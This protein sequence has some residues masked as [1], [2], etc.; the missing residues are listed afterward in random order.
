MLASYN[1][2]NEYAECKL[3]ADEASKQ[4]TA[5]GLEVTEVKH[6]NQPIQ[7][8]VIAAI[9]TI[10]K[11]P[12]ADKLSLVTVKHA[13]GTQRVVCGAQNISV[14]KK[15]VFAKEG[16]I[17]PGNFAIKKTSIRG[18]ESAG[19]ICSKQELELED[20]S[21]G[22][23]ILPDTASLE[24]NVSVYTGEED[25]I[26]DIDLTANRSDCMSIVGI[27]QELCIISDKHMSIKEHNKHLEKTGNINIAVENPSACPRYTARIIQG[28]K[29]GPS[30][31]WIVKRLMSH[32]IRSINNI[33]DI[34]N[35]ILL[36]YGQP[37][38][39]F[40]YNKLSG[41]QII[42]RNAKK[43]EKI[44]TLDEKKEIEL[45][46]DDLVICD[47]EKPV[48]L[49]GIMGGED[50]GV[51][52][53]T[54]DILLES[55]YFDPSH[56]RATSRRHKISSDS[57]IRFEK[58]VNIDRVISSLHYAE[59]LILK[60]AGGT[61]A[62]STKDNYPKKFSLKEI[63][64]RYNKLNTLLGDIIPKKDI[65][66]IFSL[67]GFE[68]KYTDKEKL[69]VI[70]PVGRND[71]NEEWDLIE[72]I[73]RIYGYDRIPETIPFIC[74]SD[75]SIHTILGKNYYRIPPAL[76]YSQCINY[77]FAEN[78]F[79]ESYAPDNP[80]HL[81]VVNPVTT[82]TSYMRPN[83]LN[84]LLLNIKN[85]LEHRIHDS[86][87][88]Y[89]YGKV[90][91]KSNKTDSGF[92][93]E[94]RIAF[95]G[96]GSTESANWTTPNREYDFYDLSGDIHEFLTN[97]G[98]TKID[99]QPAQNTIFSPIANADVLVNKKKVGQLGL[100]NRN[101]LAHFG[102]EKHKIYYGE[103][104]TTLIDTL[105]R[106]KTAHK[107]FSQYPSVYRDIALVFDIQDPVNPTAE[108]IQNSD[109]AVTDVIITDIYTGENI[110]EHKKS[111]V[112]SVA[113]TSHDKTFTKEEVDKIEEQIIKKILE[114]HN[115]SLR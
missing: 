45:T 17:L 11:H 27:A 105:N 97:S 64:F 65:H 32:G 112:Y 24:E 40:D 42:V 49:A 77:S 18:V 48:A 43:G 69:Q 5:L 16:T 106:K 12:D 101:I 83:L 31:D 98:F 63:F 86:N 23:W 10:E 41:H 68:I 46:P 37:M 95:I 52:E 47:N 7:G 22:V 28:V 39:A 29:I 113:Y 54:I 80:E 88:L 75:L 58:K 91:A 3:P 104:S 107:P 51:T 82:D 4:L 25:Y 78:K 70:V 89:E 90:F 67:L 26:F 56:I 73:V 14:G 6:I 76:G 20:K 85:N 36:E 1:W 59:E 111:V 66:K 30:P 100:L 55:A 108:T 93:E 61:I 92:S 21:D 50:T 60:Y 38:H 74:N 109:N 57:S 15:I 35:Y 34:T 87:K 71:I 81:K 2:L 19:M 103:I 94:S 44:Q 72:E 96:T 9:S 115:V 33:V 62:S 13:D 99:I 84:G 114:K 8:L 102:L 53:A 110:G 79:L